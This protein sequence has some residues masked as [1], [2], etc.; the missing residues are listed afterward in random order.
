M[1]GPLIWL[2]SQ[3]ERHRRYSIKFSTKEIRSASKGY[4]ATDKL[5]KYHSIFG[6]YN[7]YGAEGAAQLIRSVLSNPSF[8]GGHG[9]ILGLIYQNQ[10]PD[11]HW[12]AFIENPQG[13]LLTMTYREATKI[14]L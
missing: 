4:D 2:L 10:A 13:Y 14:V 7:M 9:L 3:A 12:N 6:A 8:N 11:Y 1:H 5:W